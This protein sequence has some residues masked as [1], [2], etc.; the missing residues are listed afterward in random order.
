MHTRHK[1]ARCVCVS[2]LIYIRDPIWNSYTFQYVAESAWGR[3]G[4]RRNRIC[5]SSGG[6]SS[7]SQSQKTH[8]HTHTHWCGVKCIHI[9]VACCVAHWGRKGEPESASNFA[10]AAHS[11]SQISAEVA[12][13]GFREFT[14]PAHAQ[15]APYAI[16]RIHEDTRQ[17]SCSNMD[18][19][20]QAGGEESLGALMKTLKA[21][22]LAVRLPASQYFRVGSFELKH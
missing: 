8:T 3:M 10:L 14:R 4:T 6:A 5:H 17:K 1:L 12:I 16:P 20:T 21:I 2:C 11:L 19:A 18:Y 15:A 13:L 7:K 22:A 9:N